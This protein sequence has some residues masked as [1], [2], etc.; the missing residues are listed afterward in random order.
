M[1]HNPEALKVAQDLLHVLWRARLEGGSLRMDQW[2][3]HPARAGRL[4][5]GGHWCGTACCVAG[6]AA[7]YSREDYYRAESAYE[8]YLELD[9]LAGR[10]ATES[11]DLIAGDYSR[12][13]RERVMDVCFGGSRPEDFN[14]QINVFRYFI[15]RE[16]A[17]KAYEDMQALPRKK[18]RQVQIAMRKLEIAA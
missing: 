4:G 15:S 17:R 6:Y 7:I 2:V 3:T 1:K 5:Q 9:E 10:L 11:A 12:R 14:A 18:R 16:L 8:I 13:V